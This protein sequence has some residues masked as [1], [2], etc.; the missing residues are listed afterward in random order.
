M[1]FTTDS[2]IS[3]IG[4]IPWGS[5]F[6][7]LYE[8]AADL[9]EILI[10]YFSTGLRNNERCVWITSKPYTSEDALRDLTAAVPDLGH[11]ILNEQLRICEFAEWYVTAE[12]LQDAPSNVGSRKSSEP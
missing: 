9:A 10:P 7:H 5:H 3:N 2:G 4:K 6:C 11:K 12:S 1:S 8:T